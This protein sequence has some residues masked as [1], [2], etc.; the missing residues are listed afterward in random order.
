MLEC[1]ETIRCGDENAFFIC[2]D[3]ILKMEISMLVGGRKKERE[4]KKGIYVCVLECLETIRCGDE[5]AFFW[6]GEGKKRKREKEGNICMCV[7]MPRDD[8]VW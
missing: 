8:S 4:R 2:C 3:D 6:L 1:P 5:N 7:G